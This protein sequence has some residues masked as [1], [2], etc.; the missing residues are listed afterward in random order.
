MGP[1]LNYRRARRGAPAADP[2]MQENA[3]DARRGLVWL[4]GGFVLQ[5]L[6]AWLYA[7]GR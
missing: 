4:I 6:G 5:L 2:S 3:A 7:F 1:I